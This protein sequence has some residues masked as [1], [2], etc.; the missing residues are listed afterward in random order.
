M[1]FS[2]K[3]K[4]DKYWGDP[5]KMNLLIFIIIVVDPRDKLEYME[6][7]LKHIHRDFVSESLNYNVKATLYELFDDY[8]ASCKPP[9]HFTS[10]SGHSFVATKG[11][12]GDTVKSGSLLKARFKK[13]K[14]ELGQYETQK[15]ELDIYLS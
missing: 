3:A 7:I 12:S 8:Y 9:L 11:T 10:Q 2:M 6:L 4:C 15:I 13:H 5:Q 14:L 1:A